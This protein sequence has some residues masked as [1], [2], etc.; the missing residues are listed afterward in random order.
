MKV[1]FFGDSITD[2]H[3]QI[4]N[5]NDLGYGFVKLLNDQYPQIQFINRGIS[6]HKTTDLLQRFQRDVV[7]ENPDI[8]FLFIGINDAWHPHL[9][10]YH[11][12]FKYF[13]KQYKSL[14][15]KLL[16]VKTIKNLY[17]VLPHVFKIHHIDQETFDDI[18]LVRKEIL[19][20]AHKYELSFV[21][22]DEKFRIAQ[23]TLDPSKILADGVH[24]TALGYEL[25][26]EV[27]VDFI[28]SEKSL[29]EVEK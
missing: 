13:S 18:E 21:S 22:F 8:V 20:Y 11:F 24:P 7:L 14:I 10:Q 26:Y 1:L 28:E 29:E 19:K 5:P 6:G 4:L 25:M 17:L 3:R 27:F 23:K 9:H 12:D 16:Q 2:A 15:K